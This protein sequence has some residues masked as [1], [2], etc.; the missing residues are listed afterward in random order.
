MFV[1]KELV[2]NDGASKGLD[3]LLDAVFTAVVDIFASLISSFTS[4]L[5]TW[6]YVLVFTD[7]YILSF[8]PSLWRQLV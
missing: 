1:A 8:S 2:R 3:R 5:Y 4:L 7:Q 6:H